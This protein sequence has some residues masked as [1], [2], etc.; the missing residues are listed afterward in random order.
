M[1]GV[2]ITSHYNMNFKHAIT[3]PFGN[4]SGDIDKH[5]LKLGCG[6]VSISHESMGYIPNVKFSY[7]NKGNLWGKR[8]SNVNGRVCFPRIDFQFLQTIT[9]I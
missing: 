6:W 5:P 9:N 4:S 1:Y 8:Y 7:I 3:S 2:S